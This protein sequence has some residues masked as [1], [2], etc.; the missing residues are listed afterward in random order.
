MR[1]GIANQIDPGPAVEGNSETIEAPPLP[2]AWV[3]S[4]D[5]FQ[6]SEIV[7]DAFGAAFQHVFSRLKHTERS[8]F[9]PIV[10]RLDH[11]WYSR[12]A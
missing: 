5:L 6:R 11:L 8:N 7:H 4:P 9:E 1:H 12:V 3:N 2:T 10:T